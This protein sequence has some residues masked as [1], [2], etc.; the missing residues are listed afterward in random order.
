MPSPLRSSMP[1]AS[2]PVLDPAMSDRSRPDVA[3]PR[4]HRG[5]PSRRP[6]AALLAASLA[7]GLA[8]CQ[9][10]P[11]GDAGQVS[12][13]RTVWV[14]AVEAPPAR[15]LSYPGTIR[16]RSDVPFAFRVGGKLSARL[17]DVGDPVA[18]GA[19][20]ARLDPSDLEATLSAETARERAARAEA[21]RSADDLTRVAALKDKGHVSQAALDRAQAAA[22]AASETLKAARERRRLAENQLAYAVLR[23]DAEGVVTSVLAEPGE[24]VALGQPVIRMARTDAPEAEVAIPEA[25]IADVAGAKATVTLWAAP[26]R[27]FPATLRELSPQADREARTFTARFAIEGAQDVARLGMTAT[28][29]LSPEAATEGVAVPLSAVWYRGEAAHVWRAEPGET[30][31][32]AVPVAVVRF[33]AA[34]AIVTG[35]LPLGA[36]VVSLGAHRLDETRKVRVE[37]RDETGPVVMGAAR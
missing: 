2:H 18:P 27:A 36:H 4:E 5:G 10:E 8:A 14:E 29:H 1:G 15:R 7:V 9:P 13:P 25:H 33:D 26:E 16:A 3:D 22:D 17:V 11:G 31:V 20:I 28:V 23:A 24:V 30:Q 12:E 32:T 21:E 6:L 37:L 34:H 19:V 35:E